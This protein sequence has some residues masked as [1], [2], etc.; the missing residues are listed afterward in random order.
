[1]KPQAYLIII[2]LLLSALLFFL[3]ILP[4]YQNLTVLKEEISQKT[5]EFQTLENHFKNLQEISEKLKEY[6]NSLSKIDSALPLSPSLPELFNF[7]QRASSQSGLILKKIGPFKV[8]VVEE[9]LKESKVDLTL[10]GDYPFFKNFLSSSEKSARLIKIE[11]I[12]FS[13]PKEGESFDF[14][15]TI[16]VYSY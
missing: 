7:L 8:S 16:K 10:S 4:K 12:S 5:F 9:E 3:L 11:K 14:D 6:Q 1:M 15:L 13:S 2:S